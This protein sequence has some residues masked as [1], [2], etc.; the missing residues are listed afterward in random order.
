MKFDELLKRHNVSTKLMKFV[1]DD[2]YKKDDSDK[3]YDNIVDAYHDTKQ[4]QP[5]EVSAFTLYDQLVD[6][7]HLAGNNSDQLLEIIYQNYPNGDLTEDDVKKKIVAV[8]QSDGSV[9]TI[10]DLANQNGRQIIPSW[11]IREF[12]D[13]YN[14]LAKRVNDKASK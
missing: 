8:S 10:Y 3:Q 4:S 5:D 2:P 11:S 13:Q 9:T 6:E 14:E 7:L 12:V 1:D